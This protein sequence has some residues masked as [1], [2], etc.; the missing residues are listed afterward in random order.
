MFGLSLSNVST[1]AI[2]AHRP[3]DIAIV[4]DYSGSMNNESDLWNCESYL[5]SLEGTPNNTDPVFPQFGP[6]NT[7]FSPLGNDAMHEHRSAS[8]V[9]QCD[10][11]RVR[12]SGDGQ[13]LLPECPRRERRRGFSPAPSTITNTVNGGDQ[14]LL[15]KNS[16]QS[17]PN[18]ARHHRQQ[19]D[20]IQRL[21][22]LPRRQVLRL[23]P[24]ARLLGQDVLHLAPRSDQRLAED[25][26]SS[27]PVGG[28]RSERRSAAVRIPAASWNNPDGQLRH[29]LQGDPQLDQ[30]RAPIRF[31]PSCGPGN[32]LFYSSIPTDVPASA[33]TWSNANNLITNPDQ[34]FWKEYIDFTLGV[35]QD[36][37]GN[38]QTPGNPS[39]SIGTDFTCG[40]DGGNRCFDHGPRRERS[41]RPQLY[42]N[43]TDN[44]K[45]PRH[46]F[47]FG[48]MTMIQFLSDT[49]RLPGTSHDISM[50]AAKLGI[51]GR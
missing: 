32:I 12:R 16:H 3:R 27:F 21:R 15:A 17:G 34:R 40:L 2:A 41:Q 8:R 25:S 13:R 4:L 36:P 37:F 9:V 6:Y 14:Y 29:Q 7:T 26:T 5:G 39:C 24:R 42:V 22:F 10:A 48:P 33:Y 47:W 51:A 35:W 19:L 18:L 38:I 49:G 11:I 45:R 44:P 20:R 28:S 30:R 46:R 23:Y 43:A 1:V 50:V 31:R